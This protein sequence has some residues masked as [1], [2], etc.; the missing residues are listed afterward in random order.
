MVSSYHAFRIHDV[1]P[2]V[3][4]PC[5]FGDRKC[6]RPVKCWLLVCWWWHFHWHFVWLITSGV[7]TTT[8]TT[9]TS[10][11]NKI[12]NDDMRDTPRALLIIVQDK[13]LVMANPGLENGF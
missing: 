8:T 5:W 2:S 11:C 3:L 9:T 10:S 12:Q 6:I 1:F 7:T 4:G 13:I